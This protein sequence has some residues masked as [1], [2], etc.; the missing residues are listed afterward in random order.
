MKKSIILAGGLSLLALASCAN[1]TDSKTITVC[2]SSLPH[3]QI[4]VNAIKPLLEKQGYKL[5]TTVLDWTLQNDAV[6]NKEYDANYFQHRPYLQSWETGDSN[7]NAEYEYK[8]LFPAAAV[9]FEPLRIYAGKKT[10]SQFAAEKTTSTYVICNDGTNETRALDLLV[11]SGVISSYSTD[12]KG[13]PINLPSN[14]KAVSEETLAVSLADYDYGVL[15]TNT[16][17]TGNIAGDDL[18]PVEGDEVADLRANVIV[19]RVEDYATD[20]IY[21]AKIKALVEASLDSSI[22]T[23]ITTTWN[24]VIAAYQKDLLAK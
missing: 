19:A 18:L 15:P 3:E 22:A 17:L 10:A 14:I 11:K 16:A 23:Y 13:S 24:N 20:S 8:T 7:Y 1:S 21:N 9:H 6:K 4:L 12:S 5:K 2:C